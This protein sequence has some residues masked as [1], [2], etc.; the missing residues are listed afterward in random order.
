MEIEKSIMEL[1]KQRAK[2]KEELESLERRKNALRMPFTSFMGK[3]LRILM[4]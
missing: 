2:L 3:S 4:T 1:E